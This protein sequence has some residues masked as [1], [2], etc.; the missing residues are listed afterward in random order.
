MKLTTETRT[1]KDYHPQH[2]DNCKS[3]RCGVC[4]VGRGDIRGLELSM[5]AEFSPA[6]VTPSDEEMVPHAF[7]AR[8]D[9][10][11][12]CN[13]CEYHRVLQWRPCK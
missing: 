11:I 2:D 12:W 8:S 7:D 6:P 13:V 9:A 4:Q 10:G 1:L 3:F 5:L